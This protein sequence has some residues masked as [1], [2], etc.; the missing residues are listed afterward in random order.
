[1][2][3]IKEIPLWTKEYVN[4]LFIRRNTKDKKQLRN[5][6]LY[7]LTCT[8]LGIAVGLIAN[9]TLRSEVNSK[10]WLIAILFIWLDRILLIVI[11]EAGHFVGGIITSYRFQLFRVFS[12]CIV[13][14]DNKYKIEK[15]KIPGTSGQ[16]LM[17]PPPNWTLDSPSFLYHAGGGIATLLASI[18]AVLLFKRTSSPLLQNISFVFFSYGMIVTILNLVPFQLPGSNNDG[19]NLLAIRRD[20]TAKEAFFKQLECNAWLSE[21]KKLEDISEDYLKL[22]ETAVWSEP[23]NYYLEWILYSKYLKERELDK[24]EELLARMEESYHNMLLC[25]KIRIDSERLYLLIICQADPDCI[26]TFYE[27]MAEKLRMNKMCTPV[28]RTL[29]IYERYSKNNE[30]VLAQYQRMFY[31]AM[32]FS[33]CK[34]EAEVDY[35]LTFQEKET[36][37]TEYKE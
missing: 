8:I 1:M 35:I 25:K 15:R 33:A 9:R 32:E 21:G 13:K 37:N 2:C 4:E 23:L 29:I 31:R 19:A 7:F 16:C 14:E 26:K 34:Q 18:F 6:I 3:S 11:H 5:S 30:C 17:K 27:N 36:S 12:Y 10:F 22:S 20:N 24:A 28:L